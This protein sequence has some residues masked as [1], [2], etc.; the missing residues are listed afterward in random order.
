MIVVSS[1][2]LLR[3]VVQLGIDSQRIDL[4]Q[5]VYQNLLRLLIWYAILSRL[6]FEST[7]NPIR[8]MVYNFSDWTQFPLIEKVPNCGRNSTL[9]RIKHRF[10]LDVFTGIFSH[11]SAIHNS[12]KHEFKLLSE[13][14]IISIQIHQTWGHMRIQARNTEI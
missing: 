12:K 1:D 14:S 3:A 10:G 5:S 2:V 4:A 7:I 11:N 8:F 13:V 6:L 9:M